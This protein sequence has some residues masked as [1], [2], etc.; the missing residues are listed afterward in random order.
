M[1][2][3]ILFK[4]YIRYNISWENTI[5]VLDG[6]QTKEESTDN[7]HQHDEHLS[8]PIGTD[9]GSFKRI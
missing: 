7:R 9:K 2:E 3:K 4:R 8:S 6:C 1:G 5:T